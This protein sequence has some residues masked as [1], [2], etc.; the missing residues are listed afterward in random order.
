MAG[1]LYVMLCHT[2][3]HQQTAIH[4]RTGGRW[5]FTLLPSGNLWRAHRGFSNL[6]LGDSAAD[7]FDDKVFA[8][9]AKKRLNNCVNLPFQHV[10]KSLEFVNSPYYRFSVRCLTGMSRELVKA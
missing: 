1:E 5:L 10:G 6:F 9:T 2:Q 8:K 3:L 7:Q 4:F